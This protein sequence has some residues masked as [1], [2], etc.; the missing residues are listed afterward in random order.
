MHYR[1]AINGLLGTSARATG[2]DEGFTFSA[3]LG[4]QLGRGWEVEARA[5]AHLTNEEVTVFPGLMLEVDP[6]PS[7][8]VFLVRKRF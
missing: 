7:G 2:S 6:N 8:M 1:Y 5:D 4:F 3:G